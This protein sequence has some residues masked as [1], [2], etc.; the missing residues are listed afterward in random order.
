MS[1]GPCNVNGIDSV[2][3]PALRLGSGTRPSVM[4]NGMAGSDKVVTGT[5]VLMILNSGLMFPESPNTVKH[6]LDGQDT[7]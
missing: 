4:E 6:T 1:A 2:R 7:P 3:G 5:A